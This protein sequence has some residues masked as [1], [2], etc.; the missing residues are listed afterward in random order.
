[1]GVLAPVLWVPGVKGL[2]AKWLFPA[3]KPPAPP[4]PP[5]TSAAPK[6]PAPTVAS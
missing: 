4:A 3:P 6:P 2:F 5:A 1:L